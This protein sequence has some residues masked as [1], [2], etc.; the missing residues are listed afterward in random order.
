MKQ[1]LLAKGVL[2][3]LAYAFI[4]SVTSLVAKLVQ[5]E[6]AVSVLVF[7]QS[8]ICV[9]LLLP[10]QKGYW[11]RHPINIWKTH[12]FRSISG[13]LGFYFFYLA[14]NHIPLVEASMLRACAPL[15]VPIVVL[16]IHKIRVPSSRWLPLLLGFIGVALIIKP[17]P[18]QFDPW[19]LVG[20]LSA[21]GLALSMVTTRMLSKNVRPKETMTIYFLI[22][23]CLSLLLSL[24]DGVSLTLPLHLIPHVM[25]VGL[26]LYFAM[27]LYTLA[28]GF[29]PASIVSPVSYIGVVFS[30][31]WG[32]LI[33]GHV[34][35]LF[36]ISGMLLIF[37]SVLLTTY[38][39]SR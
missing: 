11:K 20:F 8:V 4:M 38:L 5:E 19:Q 36:A 32:M 10:Q 35:D 37:S 22:S 39:S 25:I 31:L 7:W 26:T 9:L 15:C 18:N 17:T 33:W 21:I 3:T 16:L 28:Y 27:Y 34:P 13:F 12:F 6:V 23:A 1:S 2:A 14:I 24:Y 29:A 30:G